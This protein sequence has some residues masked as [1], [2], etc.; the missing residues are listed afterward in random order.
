MTSNLIRWGVRDQ[1]PRWWGL[2]FHEVNTN[3]QLIKREFSAIISRKG[4]TPSENGRMGEF[5]KRCAIVG[6]NAW[7]LGRTGR[8]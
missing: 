5:D 7:G 3:L 2:I 1:K 4:R 6:I 8:S